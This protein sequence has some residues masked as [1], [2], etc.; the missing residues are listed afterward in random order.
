M[1]SNLKKWIR[2][3]L[4][5]L[6]NCKKTSEL[7]ILP[8]SE[9]SLAS[10]LSNK[11]T[12]SEIIQSKNHFIF[13]KDYL[14]SPDINAQTIVIEDDYIN[15]DFLHDYASYY[16]LCFQPYEKVCK[17]VHFFSDIFN[18][19]E[20]NNVILGIESQN[21]EFW[22]KYLGFIVVKPIPIT[23]IGYSVLKTYSS[24]SISI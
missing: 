11:Y 13:L 8:Y 1:F 14:S 12:T 24:D 3:G 23:I 17:R 19:Q 15:K 21:K 6:F 16:A 7:Q 20:L 10:A 4:E 9:K 22:D 5:W 18:E 2:I